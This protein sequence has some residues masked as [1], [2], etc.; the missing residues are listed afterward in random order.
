MA[1]LFDLLH[2]QMDENIVDQLS[3]QIGGADRAQTATAAQSIVSTLL[4]GLAKNASTP[5]GAASLNNALERDHDGG[6][7]GNLMGLIG[8]QV[9]PEQSRAA[10]GAGIL[11]HILGNNQGSAIDMISKMS[12][13][14]S[15]QTGNLMT[16]LA[17]MVMSMLGQQKKQ[18]GLDVAGIA[19]LLTNSVGQQKQAGNPLMDM[20]TRFLDKDGDGSMMDDVAGMVGKGLLSNLFGRK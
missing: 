19:G 18:Q 20:A 6:L 7:L 11:N 5:D 2:G 17:P 16:T 8:G 13:L 15:G 12:G 3:N 9:A 14:N 10:N 1:N 4:A